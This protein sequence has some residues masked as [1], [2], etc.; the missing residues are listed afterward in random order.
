MNK[1]SRAIILASTA[2]ILLIASTGA[3]SQQSSR[4]REQEE[5]L[6]LSSTLV[7]VPT[8][9]TDRAGRFIT[10]LA[11]NEF[12]VFEDGKRQEVSIFTA[13]KQPFN[14][15]LVL[16]TSNSAEDRLRAIQNVA[17][18]FARET[19][20]DDRMMVISFDNEVRQLTDFTSDRQEIEAA[21]KG[22]G[23][24]FGKLLYEA[25]V[26]ALEQLREREGRRAVI[27]LTDG[28]DMR[29]IEATA[30]S[31]LRLA[32]ETGAV[33]YI[34]RFDT[35]WWI[36]SEARRQKSAEPQS[37]VP[38]SIDGRI[39]LPP[40]F[41]G[42]D[43]TPTGLPKV[44]GPRIEVGSRTS[45]RVTVI[46]GPNAKPRTIN[47]PPP[48]EITVNLDKLYGEADKFLQ[49]ISSRTAGRLFKAETFDDTRSA[50]AAIAD[51][52][53][54]LYMIGYY[55]A[56]ERRDGKYRKIKVEVARKEVQVRARP[57][58]RSPKEQ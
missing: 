21:I 44:R 29:S 34:V 40:D 2:L 1:I 20:S 3:R 18:G 7:Q 52:L 46:D 51:E 54:N 8:V 10:D 42:P 43:V 37:N 28:V 36:E 48:D 24:G 32:E 26:R 58:Y 13:I 16:D 38:F 41:G 35:R 5:D 23:A 4:D 25:V 9:V 22:T 14:A 39:P 56:T 30:E 57:G 17:A 47:E 53:R 12:V 19:G 27:L 50:F 55:P 49:T 45:P 33:V 11:K 31:T 6:K 15:V